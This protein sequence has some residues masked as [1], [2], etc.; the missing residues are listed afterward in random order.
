MKNEWHL[1]IVGIIIIIVS[2]ILYLIISSIKIPLDKDV[3]LLVIS[4]IIIISVALIIAWKVRSVNMLSHHKI[5]ALAL[6]GLT[7]IAIVALIVALG[8][9]D[10]T[11]F[12]AVASA[13]AGGI[14]GF[15]AHKAIEDNQTVLS[16]LKDEYV[17]Q[18]EPLK[19]TLKGI[20]TAGYALTYSM[21]ASP[22]IPEGENAKLNPI[23]GEFSWTPKIELKQDEE[24][25]EC[26][27]TFRVTDSQG[28]TDSRVMKITVNKK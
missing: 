26:I 10:R 28:N 14:A 27:M 24:K 12:I 25:K 2:A 13:A 15:L 9:G 5:Q 7:S 18:D 4:G 17:K 20:S 19:F 3:Q 8:N 21:S 1:V 11:A 22:N 23:S 6:M 16:P